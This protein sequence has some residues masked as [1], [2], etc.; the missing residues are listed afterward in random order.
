MKQIIKLTAFLGCLLFIIGSCEKDTEPTWVAP[1]MTLEVVAQ[2]TIT[3]KEATLQGNIGKNELDI[4][5]CGFAY[6]KTKALLEKKVFTDSNVKKVPVENTSGTCRV[7]LEDLEPGTNYFYCIYITCGNTTVIS[8]DI[9]QF[10]TTANNAPELSEVSMLTEADN[11]SLSIQSSIV[12]IGAESITLC[13]FCYAKGA[14]KDPTLADLMANIPEDEMPDINQVEKKFS[15]TIDGLEAST[16]YSVRAYAMNDAGSVGYGPKTV[17]RTA[18]AE[19]PTVRTYEDAD[20][21]GDYAVVSA[22]IIDEGTAKV[23][24]RGFCWSSTNASPMLG[25]CEGNV[26]VALNDS[27]IFA[28]EITKLK[29]GTTYYV[30]SYAINEKGTGYGNK[31]T[32]TTTSVTEATVT[33]ADV[34]NITTTTAQLAASIGSNGNG[35]INERGFCWSS[36]SQKPEIGATGCESHAIEGENFTLVLSNLK[37]NQTPYWVVAYVKNEK[38]IAYSEVKSFETQVLDVP[39]LATPTIPEANRRS[40]PCHAKASR[41]RG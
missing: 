22:E 24:T 26:E 10:S 29:E 17:L 6:S 3:R 1:E 5:E 15:A 33:L 30:R 14:D 7:E 31:V 11:Q 23:T 38:G 40:L 19:K 20:V 25:A 9:L 8:A 36:S 35:T 32:I 39:E 16:E 27:K 41:S 2:S 28:S 12:S 34:Y 21:R 4:T 37:S 13:G 18:N